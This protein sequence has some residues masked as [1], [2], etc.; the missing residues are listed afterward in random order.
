M[1]RWEG[2]WGSELGGDME[3]DRTCG[4]VRKP[5]SRG[6]SWGQTWSSLPREMEE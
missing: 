2:G 3:L 1:L 5:C 4:L 6:S